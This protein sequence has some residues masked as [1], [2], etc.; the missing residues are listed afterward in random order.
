MVYTYQMEFLTADGQDKISPQDVSSTLQN[1]VIDELIPQFFL[2][3]R[4][5]I[6]GDGTTTTT[7]SKFGARKSAN[8]DEH[9]QNHY[10]YHIDPRYESVVGI[11]TTTT[12]FE[13]GAFMPC[14]DY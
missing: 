14:S 13:R 5:K 1:L 2:E 10:Y 7:K 3:C 9:G 11:T 6:S 8:E 4:G 12:A